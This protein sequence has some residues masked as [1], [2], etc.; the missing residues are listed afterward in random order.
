MR[1][2]Q[3]FTSISIVTFSIFL[4]YSCGNNTQEPEQGSV[5]E[6]IPADSTTIVND[7]KNNVNVQTNIISEVDSSGI[8]MFPLSM[9]ETTRNG[10]NYP[11]KEIPYNNYWNIIFY[12]SYTSA[13]HLLADKKMLIKSIN[14]NHS[15]NEYL[16]SGYT[17]RSISFT[18][19]YIFYTGIIDDF[20]SDR[21]L[22]SEDPD[23]LFVSDKAGY[24]FRQISPAGTHLKSW[25][26]IKS[27]NK[28]IMSVI[29]DTDKNKK[30]GEKDEVS[31]YQIDLDGEDQ[32]SEILSSEFKKELKILF[33]RD[34]KRTN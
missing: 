19:K 7:P 13:Y 5:T 33:D 29:K 15:T 24:N 11:Y 27:A 23:Y 3:M 16:E 10:G 32:A 6:S 26:I 21:K 2:Y 25:K 34:W 9:G 17:I 20:N 28:I 31:S 8:I 14:I 4:F 1:N 12:N 30:F 18:T 22:T